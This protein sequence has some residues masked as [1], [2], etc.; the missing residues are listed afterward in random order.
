MKSN[1]FRIFS[2]TGLGITAT[3]LS[4]QEYTTIWIYFMF[5]IFEIYFLYSCG[6]GFYLTKKNEIFKSDSYFE[7]KK[8]ERAAIDPRDDYSKFL[9]QLCIEEFILITTMLLSSSNESFNMIAV[10]GRNI[11]LFF[12]IK[13]FFSFIVSM[14][15]IPLMYNIPCLIKNCRTKKIDFL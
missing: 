12:A 3:L 1:L 13:C 4:P 15:V 9:L 5:I 11:L 2:A 14:T 10:N 8:E 6:L 7:D